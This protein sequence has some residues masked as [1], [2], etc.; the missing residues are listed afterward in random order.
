MSA[1]ASPSI[2]RNKQGI[3]AAC[4]ERALVTDSL[5]FYYHIH[6]NEPCNQKCVMCRPVGQLTGQ[7]IPFEDFVAFFE[8]VKPF[9][10]HMTLIGGE[11][12]MYRWINEVLELLAEHPIAVTINTN[13]FMLRDR[14]IPRLLAVHELNLKCSIDAA[15]RGTYLKIRGVD[16]FDRV[17][18]N[19]RR[20]AELAR[21]RPDIRVIPHYVVMRENLGEV[22]PFVDFAKTLR[23]HRVEFD[24]VRHVSDWHVEAHTGW[25]FDG[26]DQSCESFRDEY[27]QVMRQAAAKCESE[28]LTHEVHYL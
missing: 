20:F 16:H 10:E 25:T 12:L 7:V 27:N 11:P 18:A 1:T 13:A 21:D 2:A 17:T 6:L 23:P 26:K 14:V 9:A 3:L 4:A 8:Q 15:T 24:P 19:M 5:P 28:G 22:V